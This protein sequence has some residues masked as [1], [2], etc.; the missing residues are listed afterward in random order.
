MPSAARPEALRRSL[1]QPWGPTGQAAWEASGL[2]RR[3]PDWRQLPRRSGKGPFE[4]EEERPFRPGGSPQGVWG[5]SCAATGRILCSGAHT[6]QRGAY[7]AAGRILC[8]GAPTLQRSTYSTAE[9]LLRGGGLRKRRFP[10]EGI[11]P[12]CPRLLESLFERLLQRGVGLAGAGSRLD[13]EL[14]PR[15]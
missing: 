5:S 4:P 3:S 11:L 8:S 14:L 1:T 6:L 9:R 12:E 13:R 7:S 2:E 10:S 15:L